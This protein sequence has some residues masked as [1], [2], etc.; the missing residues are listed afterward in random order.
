MHIE[1]C[2]TG[3]N[4]IIPKETCVELQLIVDFILSFIASQNFS[5]CPKENSTKISSTEVN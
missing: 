1:Q 2:N 3:N 4:E 5:L